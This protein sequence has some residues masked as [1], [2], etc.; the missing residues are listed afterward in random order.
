MES[1]NDEGSTGIGPRVGRAVMI[2]VLLAGV[3][4]AIA[5]RDAIDPQVIREFVDSLGAWGA[6]VFVGLYVI[7]ALFFLPGSVMTLA[8]GALFGAVQGTI[9]ALIGAT[10]GAAAAFV[11]A[12]Y[13]AGDWVRQKVS[14]RL[15]TVIKGVEDEGWKFVAFTRL[16]P[17]FPYNL[18]NYAFGLTR[19]K[20]THFTLASLFAMVPGAAAYAYLGHAGHQLATGT[21][22]AIQTAMIALGALGAL[23]IVSVVLKRYRKRKR[24]SSRQED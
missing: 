8:A 18:L 21:E 2:S 20:L 1:S 17:I 24:D 7:A 13:V 3:G 10:L 16:V 11:V 14:G 5:Y 6:V 12:R 4:L 9:F 19:I 22:D 15:E 23:G